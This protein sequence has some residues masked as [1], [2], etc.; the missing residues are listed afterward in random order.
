MVNKYLL[1]KEKH[2]KRINNFNMFFAFS[3][4]QLKEGLK[5]QTKKNIL[6]CLKK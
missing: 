3:K 2:E 6:K 4:E 5:K 1:L